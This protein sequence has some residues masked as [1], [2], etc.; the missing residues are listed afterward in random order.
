MLCGLPILYIHSRQLAAGQV[1]SCEAVQHFQLELTRLSPALANKPGTAVMMICP[2]LS[3]NQA[4]SDV[5]LG[6][7]DFVSSL[8]RKGCPDHL[9]FELEVERPHKTSKVMSNS[10]GPVQFQGD[11][12]FEGQH[13]F[14]LFFSFILSNSTCNVLQTEPT[15]FRTSSLAPSFADFIHESTRLFARR[16]FF[17]C[18]DSSQPNKQVRI[19]G[20]SIALWSRLLFCN[21][22]KLAS[23]V[24]V[25]QGLRVVLSNFCHR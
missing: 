5:E 21:F 4:V 25:F 10:W 24:K 14:Q 9:P 23:P 20:K 16:I 19:N 18:V 12:K 7:E 22:F 6:G 15:S 17:C 3:P 11:H 2:D 8:A 1:F 13:L